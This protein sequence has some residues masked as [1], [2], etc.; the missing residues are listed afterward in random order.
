[1]PSDRS[2]RR[3]V[4]PTGPRKARP[5]DRPRRNP[6][7]LSRT[8]G[9][10]RGVYHRARIRA[11]R[12][13]IRPTLAVSYLGFEQGKVLDKVIIQ[14]KSAGSVPISE[15]SA[16]A[17]LNIW[18]AWGDFTLSGMQN[19]LRRLVNSVPICNPCTMPMRYAAQA[20]CAWLPVAPAQ[21]PR[22][23]STVIVS[24]DPEPIAQPRSTIES[25][26]LRILSPRFCVGYNGRSYGSQR[27]PDPSHA[28]RQRASV[29]GSL[30]KRTLL[31]L[32]IGDSGRFTGNDL[33]SWAALGGEQPWRRHFVLS[34]VNVCT[35]GRLHAMHP[36]LDANSSISFLTTGWSACSASF[37]YV[38]AL[39]RRQSA[40]SV[41]YT[42]ELGGVPGMRIPRRRWQG[43]G[44]V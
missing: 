37:R 43:S 21:S 29:E 14:S 39:F 32:A 12:W 30:F 25:S 18:M 8:K 5:D 44:P 40:S 36:M 42:D 19:G 3:R 11:T 22:S 10:L 9:R 1:M 31:N 13:L 16:A 35:Q 20:V 4:S 15:R 17:L 38:T 41:H 27:R 34:I 2:A 24:H 6:P 7:L 28:A 23:C 33:T 26:N